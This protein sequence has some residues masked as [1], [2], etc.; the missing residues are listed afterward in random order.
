MLTVLAVGNLIRDPERRT[1]SKGKDYATALLRVPSAEADA[2]LV[3]V[4]TFNPDTVQALLAHGKGDELAVAGRAGL[5]S[6]EGRDGEQHGLSVVAD[7]VLS[8]YMVDKR[9][10]AATQG[11]DEDER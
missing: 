2:M 11:A 7:K 9:R 1:S 4:I 3:S 8:T 10:K 5:R 6:W